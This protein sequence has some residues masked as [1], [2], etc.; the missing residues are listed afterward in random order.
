MKVSIDNFLDGKVKLKQSF[1]GYRA[2]SDSVLL[3]SAVMAKEGQ[4]VLD[5]GAA[6]G[7]V[8]FCLNA[9][10]R[11]LKITGIDIQ[12][13]LILLAKEN[14]SLNQANIEFLK[15]DILKKTMF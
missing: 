5:V 7:V 9:R 1:D 15:A 4:R 6:G 10:I 13:D 11:G 3:A 14:N 2:T 12:D 8:S